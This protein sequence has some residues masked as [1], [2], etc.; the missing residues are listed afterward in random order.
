MD[1]LKEHRPTQIEEMVTDKSTQRKL[2][3]IMNNTAFQNVLLTGGP[4]VGK[5]SFARI[6]AGSLGLSEG[7]LDYKEIN[8]ADK[9]GVDY[10][11][12]WIEWL[13]SPPFTDNKILILDEAHQ[14]TNAAQLSLMKAMEDNLK[15]IYVVICSTDPQK[16]IKQIHGRCGYKVDFIPNVSDD[17]LIGGLN[18]LTEEL[19]TTKSPTP[20]QITHIVNSYVKDLT[21]SDFSV[22]NFVTGVAE[23]VSSWDEIFPS[24]YIAMTDELHKVFHSFTEDNKS[25]FLELTKWITSKCKRDAWSEIAAIVLASGSGAE[26]LRISLI[27]YMS[28]VAAG[29]PT[30]SVVI[31]LAELCDV[32]CMEADGSGQLLNA[33]LK[34]MKRVN[35]E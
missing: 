19:C 2:F 25:G 3:D 7:D 30:K 9:T 14:L 28:K 29:K 15:G 10:A 21:P 22:R 32:K 6:F 23:V 4:G 33:M 11:R 24:E 1:I 17:V 12:E 18:K 34:I 16:I 31:C 13:E 35:T 26:G 27:R 8:C 5:T 20:E